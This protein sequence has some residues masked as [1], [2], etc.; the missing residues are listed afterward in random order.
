MTGISEGGYVSD[1]LMELETSGFI[2]TYSPLENKKKDKLY[3]LTD[4]YSLFYLQFIEGNSNKSLGKWEKISQS[5]AY[6]IWCG[7]AF[8]N[9]C[10]KH[11]DQLKK[12]LGISGV[13]T[14]INSFLHR[15]NKTYEKGFQIDLLIDRKDDVINICEMKFHSEEFKI[16]ADYAQN[17][18]TKKEGLKAVTRTK[19][20]VHISFVTT[21]GLVDNQHK[22]DLVDNNF[23]LDIFF[24]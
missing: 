10:M 5:Q 12:A 14:T 3:R 1:I 18:R 23:G 20:I 16:T 22:I 11:I 9:L 19:K 15:K 6:K 7:Y 2:S 4:E 17:I 8:E 13:Q 24:E 21:Y